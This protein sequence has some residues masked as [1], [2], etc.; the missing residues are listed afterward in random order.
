MTR[1][2]SIGLA[3][4]ALCGPSAALAD[5]DRDGGVP[6]LHER[7]AA[8]AAALDAGEIEAATAGYTAVLALAERISDANLLVARAADGL[9]DAHRLAG[10]PAEAERLYLRSAALWARL[11]GE[12]QPR[13]AVTLHHL[14]STCL[15]QGR[16]EQAVDHLNRALAIWNATLGPASAEARLTGELLRRAQPR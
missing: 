3:A 9:G 1:V 8:A 13:L 15:D 4:C 16:P 6:R 2:A 5:A 12:N 11:L 10:R 7:L 14:G